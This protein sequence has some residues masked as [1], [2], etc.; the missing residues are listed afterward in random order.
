MNA[1]P[2]SYYYKPKPDAAKQA[3]SDAELPDHTQ[4]TQG[5]CGL[6]VIGI[7][8]QQLRREGMVVN[9]KWIRRV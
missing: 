5:V 9:N 6:Q 2:S 7:W 4:P 1:A 3:K 8:P